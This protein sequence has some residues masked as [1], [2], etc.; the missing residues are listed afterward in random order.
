MLGRANLQFLVLNTTRRKQSRSSMGHEANA[1]V[2][3]FVLALLL[4]TIPFRSMN[5]KIQ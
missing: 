4:I 2:A 5:G 1:Y 3:K